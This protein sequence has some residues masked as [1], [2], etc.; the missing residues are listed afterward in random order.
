MDRIA[1]LKEEFTY[2]L[3]EKLKEIEQLWSTLQSDWSTTHL[4]ALHLKV[5]SLSGSAGIYGFNQL[6]ADAKEIDLF[7]RN[8]IDQAP[9]TDSEKE[10]IGG[11]ILKLRKDIKESMPS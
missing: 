11:K 9:P 2:K 3:P 1:A 4:K 5:H 10:F 6:S 7:L 8:F